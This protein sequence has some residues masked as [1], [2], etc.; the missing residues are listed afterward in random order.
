VYGAPVPGYQRF[1]LLRSCT[2]VSGFAVFGALGFRQALLLLDQ[3]LQLGMRSLDDQ[4]VL[5]TIVYNHA[6]Y[7]SAASRS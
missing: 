1:T 4:L 7:V 3:L 2:P 6:T 5:Q